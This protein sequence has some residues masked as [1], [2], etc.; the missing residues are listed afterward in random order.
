MLRP[1]PVSRVTGVV[2]AAMTV[3]AVTAGPVAADPESPGGFN[4]GD[5]GDPGVGTSAP[6]VDASSEDG[7]V[8]VRA[9][10]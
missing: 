10:E 2:L 7:S 9:S 8:A 3:L 6:E 4:G 5:D 1:R